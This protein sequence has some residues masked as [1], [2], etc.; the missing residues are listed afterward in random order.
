MPHVEERCRNCKFLKVH[1]RTRGRCYFEPP[2]VP[3]DPNK[4][5][6]PRLDDMACSHFEERLPTDP[7]PE[8]VIFE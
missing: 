6:E 1:S 7:E 3:Q 2:C 5:C 4:R 8:I